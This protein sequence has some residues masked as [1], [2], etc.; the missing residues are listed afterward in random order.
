[1]EVTK[2]PA[3]KRTAIGTRKVAHLREEGLVPAV[4]YGQGGEPEHVT[5][6][7]RDIDRELRK[8]HRV[9]HL[10]VEGKDE[11]VFLQD[12]QLDVL[13]DEPVHVDFLR[14]DLQKPMPVEVELLFVGIPPGLAKGG[15]MVRDHSR[16][17]VLSLPT[18]IPEEIEVKVSG[19]DLDGEI[20]AKEVELPA[21][22]TLDCPPDTVICHISS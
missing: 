5:V 20:L 21:G 6:Q 11:P 3:T 18:T 1:M 12:I 16:L 15:V 14:I 22:V 7:S 10:T 8:H 4:I 13:T 19:L 17:K 9:F 2:I